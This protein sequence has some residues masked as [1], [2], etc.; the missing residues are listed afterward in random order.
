MSSSLLSLVWWIAI[1]VVFFWMM[2]RGGCGAMMRGHGHHGSRHD[3]RGQRGRPVDPV[4][5]MELDPAHAA[6]TRVAEG[7]TYFFC[8]Q[9]C[10]DAFD[11]RPAMYA[12]REQPAEHRHHMC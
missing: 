4:C 1:A 5:G 11:Q 2:S 10:L 3:G 9:T 7:E 12:H 8:S 6:G